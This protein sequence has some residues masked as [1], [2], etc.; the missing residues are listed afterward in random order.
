MLL[1]TAR[2]QQ[3]IRGTRK[4]TSVKTIYAAKK[5]FTEAMALWEKVEVVDRETM[6]VTVPSR[7]LPDRRYKF[8]L[9]NCGCSCKTENIFR[10]S[11]SAVKTTTNYFM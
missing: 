11:K 8:S 1:D 4:H 9:L 6:T 7:T 2:Y 5:R 3:K 10:Y